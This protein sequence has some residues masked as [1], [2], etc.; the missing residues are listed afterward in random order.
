MIVTKRY[1]LPHS[2]SVRFTC[3]VPPEAHP[4][5]QLMNAEWDPRMPRF[6]SAR[7]KQKFSER[8]LEA[9]ADF[10]GIV[11][12]MLGGSVAVADMDE[13]ATRIEDVTVI[14]SPVEH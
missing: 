9:R 4:G 3:P 14:E 8:Y 13:A 7:A 11:A 5:V 12:K 1:R 6:R 2:T 10:L